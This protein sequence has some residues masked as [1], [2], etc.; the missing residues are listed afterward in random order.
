MNLADKT[1][2][3]FFVVDTC[4]DWIVRVDEFVYGPYDSF[5]DALTVAVGEAQAAGLLGFASVVLTRPAKFQPYEAC[6]TYGRDAY[7]PP[8]ARIPA[9]PLTEHSAPRRQFSLAGGSR[10]TSSWNG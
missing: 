8:A 2:L 3:A 6:W 10:R 9:I 4:F 7:W 5:A 1:E